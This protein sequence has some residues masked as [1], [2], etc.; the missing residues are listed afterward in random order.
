[1]TTA[2]KFLAEQQMDEDE[3]LEHSL[4]CSP[5]CDC[6]AIPDDEEIESG[7]CKCCGKLVEGE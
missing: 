2:Y 6:G 5:Y 3:M 7:R 1:M 4:L